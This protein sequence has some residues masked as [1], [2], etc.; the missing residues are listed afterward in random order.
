MRHADQAMYQAKQAGKNRY[1]LFDVVQNAAVQSHHEAMSDIR[2]ALDKREFVLHYQPKV[3]MK[4]GK[5]VGAEALIRWQ[6][7]ERGLLAPGLFLPGVE[8]DAVG[9]DL[10]EWVIGTA[11]G[12]MSEWAESGLQLPVSVNVGTY[13]LQHH[14]FAERLGSLLAGRSSVNPG[15]L[16]LEVLESSAVQDM[17]RLA[18]IMESCRAMGVKFAL[19]DFG[20]GYSSLSYLRRLQAETLKIDQSFVRDMLVDPD[21]LAIVNGVIGLASAFGRDVIAEGVETLAHG[22]R[23][24]ELGCHLAQ[25]YGIARPMPAE[26]IPSWIQQWTAQPVWSHA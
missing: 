19:D 17:A 24:V 25:G 7:P 10:G 21:D 5:V 14:G 2:R 22:Q 6:H 18:E 9:L 23:L 3:N 26:K 12:Q 13:Q 15:W 4:T 1:Q 11:L 8:T 20:T 16:E